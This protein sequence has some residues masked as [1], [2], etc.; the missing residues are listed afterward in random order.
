MRVCVISIPYEETS[1]DVRFQM[2]FQLDL[3]GD[4]DGIILRHG[5][6][7]KE[8]QIKEGNHYYTP[9]DSPPPEAVDILVNN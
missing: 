6:K 4:A 1:P 5:L 8:N 3:H 7:V 9:I 2:I